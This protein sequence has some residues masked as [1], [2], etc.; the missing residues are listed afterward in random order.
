MAKVDAL[1][2][3]TLHILNSLLNRSHLRIR[4]IIQHGTIGHGSFGVIKS[5]VDMFTGDPLLAI[6]TLNYQRRSAAAIKQELEIASLF[7]SDC[8]AVTAK[9]P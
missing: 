9:R 5:G 6:E 3:S 7:S 4:S 8:I 1:A 2:A